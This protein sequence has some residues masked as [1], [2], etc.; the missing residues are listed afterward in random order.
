MIVVV[1]LMMALAR[2][3][4]NRAAGAAFWLVLAVAAVQVQVWRRS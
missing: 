1:A 4:D 3:Y 2:V